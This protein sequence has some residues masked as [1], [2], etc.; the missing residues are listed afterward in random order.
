MWPCPRETSTCKIKTCLQ[1]CP[2]ETVSLAASWNTHPS[3]RKESK[4]WE[5]S[6]IE[7]ATPKHNLITRLLCCI[8]KLILIKT[9]F[10]EKENKNINEITVHKKIYNNV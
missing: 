6:S 5:I 8:L 1:G 2:V 3:Y 10:A 7:I 9:Q 4:K